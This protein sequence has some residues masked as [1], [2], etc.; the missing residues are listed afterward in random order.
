M[1]RQVRSLFLRVPIESDIA[2]SITSA[3]DLMYQQSLFV[4]A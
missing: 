4:L 2:H 3:V 1:L